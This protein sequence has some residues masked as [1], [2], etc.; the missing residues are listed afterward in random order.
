MATGAAWDLT[1]PLKPVA[2]FDPDAVRDIP[3]E[4]DA[5]LADIGST[6]ASHEAYV[7]PG[8]LQVVSSSEAGGVVKVRVQK[9]PA[10]T[11][12]PGVKYS[13]RCRIVAANGEQDDQTVWLKITEK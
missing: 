8:G 2:L 9:D 1:N 13:V 6:H 3:F 10:G 7:V 4:W 11:L 12:T 5:W